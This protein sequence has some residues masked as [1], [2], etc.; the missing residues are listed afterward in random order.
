MNP[1]VAAMAMYD[2]PERRAEV[3][4]EWALVRERLRAA[5]IEAPQRLAR[6][7]GDL[8]DVP[9]GIRDRGGNLIAP[10]PASLPPDEL[11][12]HTLWRH[13]A[14]LV[15]Q[16]CWGPMLDTGLEKEVVV[17]AQPS[18]DGIEGGEGPLYSSAIVTRSD[19]VA[20]EAVA[21]PEDGQARLP[22]G[23]L[24]GLRLAFNDWHSMSGLLGL[25]AD[26]ESAG[27][28]LSLFSEMVE[29]GAHRLSVRAIAEGRADVATIDCRSWSYS[30]MYEPAAAKLKVIGWT[31]RR[32]GLPFVASRHLSPS[33]IAALK[34]A[35]KEA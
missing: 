29:T 6:C 11:D 32:M 2:W 17:L 10:D 30:R 19:A 24:R 9:G 23:F 14:L 16:T 22:L 15:A 34:A 1:T 12:F 13:P 27:E 35:F 4:A 3:D 21:S 33:T 8:P 7:N 28:D 31:A 20:S 18:Y 25:K 26:L 5:G